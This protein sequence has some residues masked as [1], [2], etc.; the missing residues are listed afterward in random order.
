MQLV[1]MGGGWLVMFFCG[2]QFL[3]MQTEVPNAVRVKTVSNYPIRDALHIGHLVS[4]M[5]FD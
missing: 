3:Q 2:G 5:Y 1:M 4:H